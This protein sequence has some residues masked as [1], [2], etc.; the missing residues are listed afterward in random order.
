MNPRN[1]LTFVLLVAVSVL[2]GLGVLLYVRARPLS[3]GEG[4]GTPVANDGSATALAL[5][6]PPDHADAQPRP[7]ARPRRLPRRRCPQPHRR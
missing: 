4:V 1:V 5:S 6:A 7:V 2:T 3:P